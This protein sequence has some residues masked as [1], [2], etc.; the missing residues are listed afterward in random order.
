MNRAATF[1]FLEIS[2]CNH[3]CGRLFA[4]LSVKIKNFGENVVRYQGTHSWGKMRSE[5]R[6]RTCKPAMARAFA[7][8]P[9]VRMSV[10]C[11]A[12]FLPLP[13]HA[14]SSNFAM[15]YR[16]SSFEG[17]RTFLRWA[18]KRQWQ[19]TKENSNL[20]ILPLHTSQH[21]NLERKHIHKEEVLEWW[22]CRNSIFA[23]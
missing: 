6:K 19:F 21:C 15:S 20:R 3:N 14:A 12:P 17:L 4:S 23:H 13:A 18:W 7:E 1:L 9:S 22:K 2:S 11:S 10:H 16:W 8:S 5:T